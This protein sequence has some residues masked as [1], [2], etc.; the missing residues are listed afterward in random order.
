M[1]ELPPIIRDQRAADADH[2]RLLS[3]FHF[4][5]AAL[6]VA[7]IGFLG[8]HF[9]L[10]HAIMDNPDLWKNQKGGTPIPKDFFN[11]FRWFYV[12]FGV[13]LVFFAVANLLSGLFIRGRRHRTFSLVVAGLN[14]IQ[15]PFGTVLGVF[16]FFVLL[17]PSVE[18]TYEA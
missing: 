17:R 16:T 13:F 11:I 3:I 18:E 9:L 1:T 6:A 8:L 2:M 14:C 15:V 5:F 12:V 7:G 10:F 4:V